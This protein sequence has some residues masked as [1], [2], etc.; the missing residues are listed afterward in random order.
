MVTTIIQKRVNCRGP[1]S[2]IL[3]ETYRLNSEE[4]W[5]SGF[6]DQNSEVQRSFLDWKFFELLIFHWQYGSGKVFQSFKYE[7]GG[8]FSFKASKSGPVKVNQIL[9]W[10]H[11]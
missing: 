2:E 8:L 1:V 6:S 3:N 7:F 10:I 9:F 5:S 11:T 4:N